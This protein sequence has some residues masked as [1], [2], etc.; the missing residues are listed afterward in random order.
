MCWH[1]WKKW[2]KYELPMVHVDTETGKKYEYKDLRQERQCEKCN[3]T[4]DA[5]IR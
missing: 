3:K 2:E 4:E 1:K 5:K